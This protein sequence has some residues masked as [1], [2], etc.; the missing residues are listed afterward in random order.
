M[1]ELKINAKQ[2]DVISC[3]L[4]YFIDNVPEKGMQT[5][6]HGKIKQEG[7]IELRRMFE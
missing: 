3:V 6:S 2:A 1:Q 4:S 7:L 5:K